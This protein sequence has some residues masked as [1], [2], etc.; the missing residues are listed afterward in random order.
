MLP[1]LLFLLTLLS[2]LAMGAP[3]PADPKAVEP[4]DAVLRC[5]DSLEST[6]AAGSKPTRPGALL[7][8]LAGPGRKAS[9]KTRV[10]RIC[11]TIPQLTST[12]RL[13]AVELALVGVLGELEAD[14]PRLRIVTRLALAGAA[15]RLAERC[16]KGPPS[17]GRSAVVESARKAERRA[18]AQLRLARRELTALDAGDALRARVAAHLTLHGSRADT[19]AES[20]GT[21]KAE[22]LPRGARRDLVV[23]NLR[24]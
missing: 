3:A 5:L 22:S 9:A 7:T 11:A 12:T 20:K 2:A 1:R 8:W 10:A 4:R 13:L 23:S 17:A 18:A 16:R 14:Q 6:D 19:T 15:R 24:P 21:L